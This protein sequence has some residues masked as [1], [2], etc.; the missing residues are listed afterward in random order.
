ML[1][2]LW[3]FGFPR[4]ALHPIWRHVVWENDIPLEKQRAA[5]AVAYRAPGFQRELPSGNF[6]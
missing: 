5:T 2:V 3:S 4:A 6:E 1:Q